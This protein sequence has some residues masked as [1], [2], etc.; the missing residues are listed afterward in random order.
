MQ[1]DQETYRGKKIHSAEFELRRKGDNTRV[2]RLPYRY[3]LSRE[4][5]DARPNIYKSNLGGFSEQAL[6]R[7]ANAAPGEY[8]LALSLNG[9]R[10]SNVISFII[11]PEFDTGKAP[12][13]EIKSLE[14]HPFGKLASPVL[15]VIGPDS[16]NVK[17]G[18]RLPGSLP[19]E[20][21][22]IERRRRIMI[23]HGIYQTLPVGH[24]SLGI[25]PV[26]QYSPKVAPSAKHVFLFRSQGYESK[27]FELDPADHPLNREWDARTPRM[28]D[29]LPQD[30]ILHGTI[31]NAKGKP[32]I[33]YEVIV[34]TV[35]QMGVKEI[36]DE[37]GHYSFSNI[38][39]GIFWVIV[40]PPP[41]PGATIIPRRYVE[42]VP[43]KPTVCDMD[44]RNRYQVD[45]QV[46]DHSG[47]PI[48]GVPIT[49]TWKDPKTDAEFTAE[50]LSIKDGTFIMDGPYRK[51]T[52]V[53]V[54]D[55]GKSGTK[56][57][58]SL[59]LREEVK[60]VVNRPPGN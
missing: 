43:G 26:D 47:E 1:F 42:L 35:S 39:G 46:V 9:V 51:V 45:G 30:P 18:N 55:G 8:R 58:H 41:D 38:P 32:A 52:Y 54:N 13:F 25:I 28:K 57:R 34:K 14:P 50:T 4:I 29:A 49:A 16:K 23:M 2:L 37:N 15:Y 17:F 36:T 12:T 21:D 44:F 59:K 60:F 5:D 19:I 7:L 40:S 53:A 56:P 6:R 10:C 3:Y 31:T 27:P 24:R 20:I 48:G 11:D 33:G 22:G